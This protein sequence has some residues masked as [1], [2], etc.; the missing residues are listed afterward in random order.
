LDAIDQLLSG[1]GIQKS[2]AG[3]GPN[4]SHV[5]DRADPNNMNPPRMSEFDLQRSELKAAVPNGLADDD[6]GYDNGTPLDGSFQGA[7]GANEVTEAPEVTP[8]E[9]PEDTDAG[10][11]SPAQVD[12][13]N[14]EGKSASFDA[15]LKHLIRE[16]G[17]A[18]AAHIAGEYSLQNLD[19]LLGASVKSAAYDDE[20]AGQFAAAEDFLT[21]VRADPEGFLREKVATIVNDAYADADTLYDYLCEKQAEE[22]AAMADEEAAAAEEEA[23]ALEQAAAEEEAGGEELNPEDVAALEEIA[24]G[25]DAGGEEGIGG[26][27][28]DI[29]EEELIEALSEALDANGVSPEELPEMEAANLPPEM[30]PEM[31]EASVNDMAMWAAGVNQY[32]NAVR[33]GRVQV[34]RAS[35]RRIQLANMFATQIASMRSY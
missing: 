35:V 30:P 7:D 10:T 4:S 31:K 34:K 18:K 12:V 11:E 33:S 2:A 23:A 8:S 20:T 27:D 16:Q 19:A 26:G 29:S 24:A 1:A 28:G 9:T 17:L 15:Q 6:T 32:R 21:A 14:V 22:E 3:T 13:N 5:S 25:G